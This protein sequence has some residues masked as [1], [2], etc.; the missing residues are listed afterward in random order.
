MGKKK[1]RTKFYNLMCEGEAD[2]VRDYRK[3][4]NRYV[5]AKAGEV[6]D[7]EEDK[8]VE[9]KTDKKGFK[10]ALLENYDG[11]RSPIMVKNLIRHAFDR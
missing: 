10:R 8:V 1:L 7:R 2:H 5:V 9:I 4:Q 11:T 6:Y 3:T